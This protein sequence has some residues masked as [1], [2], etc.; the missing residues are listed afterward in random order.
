M[1]DLPAPPQ[2]PDPLTCCGRH[3]DPC[4]FDYYNAAFEDWADKI[5]TLGHDPE[6]V[7][8]T[9]GQKRAKKPPR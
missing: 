2:A 7:L 9:L 8:A 3:C 1:S 5:K 6:T 4:I